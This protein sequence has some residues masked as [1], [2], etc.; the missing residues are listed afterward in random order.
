VNK[1]DEN[2]KVK[3][4]NL[5]FRYDVFQ[6]INLFYSFANIE[7][8]ED[9]FNLSIE[10]LEEEIIVQTNDIKYIVK[11]NKEFKLKEE[12][13][14]AVFTFLSESTKKVLPWGT[15]VGIRPSKKALE[16]LNG[17]Y[18]EEE[19][20]K[21][22]KD[23]YVTSKEKSRLC[24]EV[25]EYE[26]NIV[27][28]NENIISVYVGMPFCPTRCLYCSF[29]SNPIGGCKNTVKPYLE[30]LTKEIEALSKYIKDKKLIIE[31]VYFGGGT[32]TAVSEGEF[33]EIMKDIYENL[34][35]E[36]NIKEFTVEC[37]RPD[38]ITEEKL[39]SMIRYK[40]QRISINPQ[41][42]NDSTLKLI[43]RNHSSEDAVEKFKMARKLGF[44][45]INMDIIVGLPGEKLEH[46]DNTCNKIL[47]LNPDSIT[48]HG[49]SIKR[50]SKLYE[51][52]INN[53]SY[54]IP[55]QEELNNMYNATGDLAQKL[56]M[57]PYYMYR[58]KN[59]VGNMEN[60]GYSKRGKE[61]IYNI[62]MIE[63]KQTIIA[64]G[65]DAVSKIV[66]LEENRIERFGN[67]KDVREY[68]KRIDEMIEKKI[69]LLDML[70]K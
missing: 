4:N 24:I 42:M 7:F 54:E 70:Y 1:I 46:I 55:V 41:T 36:N 64:L 39:K 57:V 38:S 31:S 2:F 66:F 61:G 47:E 33:E 15:L 69:A 63:E 58:Q 14:K 51:N 30:A 60:V 22:F 12:I 37:G 32:P 67:I 68:T 29:T 9:D 28:E 23:R 3:L 49:M 13:R 44:D 48:V 16:L 5:D 59:M 56:E 35:S 11:I 40:V 20:V 18:S 17:G 62:Q 25:A 10:I 21:D 19:I 8:T 43:G 34:V 6:M 26:R 27:N 65:A 52:I 45:N 50:A 53:E